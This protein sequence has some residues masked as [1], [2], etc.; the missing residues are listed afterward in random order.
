MKIMDEDE[1]YEKVANLIL[2]QTISTTER[3]IFLKVKNN[4]GENMELKKVVELLKMQLSPLA[5]RMELSNHVI[6]FYQELSSQF[7]DRGGRDQKI[8]I[9]PY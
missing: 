9:P 7:L 5:I 6:L 3:E 4:L 2:D 1:F 8:S